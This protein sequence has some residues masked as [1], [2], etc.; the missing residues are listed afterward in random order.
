[1]LSGIGDKALLS[2]LGVKTIH[3]LPDVGK[4]LSDHPLLPVIYFVNSTNTADTVTRNVTLQEEQLAQWN[5]SHSGP[6]VNTINNQIGY[7]R[8]PANDSIFEQFPDPSA[9]PRSGHFEMLIAVS[10]FVFQNDGRLTV[11]NIERLG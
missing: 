1:M 3:H 9:G 8:L 5:K 4:N 2:K 11:K 7:F 10:E 6:L